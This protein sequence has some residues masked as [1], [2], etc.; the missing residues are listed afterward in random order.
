MKD[1]I[2]FDDGSQTLNYSEVTSKNLFLTNILD[3]RTRIKNLIWYLIP[4]VERFVIN[5]KKDPKGGNHP[6]T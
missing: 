4:K 2:F 5:F 1:K 6:G 3:S